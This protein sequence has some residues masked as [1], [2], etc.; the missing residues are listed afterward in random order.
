MQLNK[1]ILAEFP[2]FDF[3]GGQASAKRDLTR[4]PNEFKLID[5]LVI[6]PQGAGLRLKPGNVAF[7]TALSG[8]PNI[9]GLGYYN[10]PGTNDYLIAVAGTKIY[11]STVSGASFSDVTGSVTITSG[12]DNRWQLFQFNN[13]IIGVGG[14]PNAPFKITNSGNAS[15]LGGSPPSTATFGFAHANRVFLGTGDTLYYS[16]VSNG[17][18]YTSDGSGSLTFDLGSGSDLV[19]GVELDINNCLI[20]KEDSTHIMTGRSEPFPTFKLFSGVGCAGKDA[21]VVADGLAYWITRDG[22]MVISDGQNLIDVKTVPSLTNVEDLF[23]AVDPDRRPYIAGTRFRGAD[24]DWIIWSVNINDVDGNNDFAIVW[25]LNNKCFVEASTGLGANCFALAPNGTLY[26]GGF[27]GD[28]YTALVEGT[29]TEAS[30]GDSDITYS[31]QSDALNLRSLVGCL[32][33]SRFS[34]ATETAG[35]STITINYGYDD[36]GTHRSI[37]FTT[38]VTGSLWDTMVWD[39]DIW[40]GNKAAF[41]NIK[42]LGRGNYFRYE[43]TGTSNVDVR[44]N[45]FTIYGRKQGQKSFG[46]Q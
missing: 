24:F 1:N 23:A 19:A 12:R 37:D 26:F 20:F 4:N 29:Y 6:L 43:L 33:V 9:Q 28:V 16:V 5:N 34:V 18:D 41:K 44:I 39:Q 27:A 10:I 46:V 17:E 13:K 42:P 15:A 2:I 40:S 14:A 3:S 32:Q 22:K 7:N 36:A 30:N 38:T 35:T 31:L 21:A 25:D 8:T 11:R 45:G